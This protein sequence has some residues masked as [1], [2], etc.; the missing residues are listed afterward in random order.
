MGSKD[1]FGLLCHTQ[2]I[3]LGDEIQQIAVENIMNSL[4]VPVQYLIERDTH[5]LFRNNGTPVDKPKGKIKVVFSGW[6]DGDYANFPPPPF[7]QPLFISYHVNEEDK[8]GTYRNLVKYKIDFVSLADPSRKEI[9]EKY[10][11]I[12]CRDEHTLNKFLSNGYT[13]AYLSFCLTSTLGKFIAPAPTRRGILAVDV[14]EG[15]LKKCFPDYRISTNLDDMDKPKTIVMVSH[16]CSS[17]LEKN[18]LAKMRLAKKLL[19]LYTRAQVVIT[20]RLHCALPCVS[21]HTPVVFT[22]PSEKKDCRLEG[23]L[24]GVKIL[25]IDEINLEDPESLIRGIDYEKLEGTADKLVEKV[26]EFFV[27]NS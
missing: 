11:E 9:Y 12:G 1:T 14:F 16:V 20:S 5:K 22:Y 3:N 2:S 10:G 17:K 18:V 27:G 23:M 13:N 15:R 19:K 21:L 25:G 8:G 7:V 6:F 4:G 26:K 24:A